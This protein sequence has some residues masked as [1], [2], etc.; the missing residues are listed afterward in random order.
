[1]IQAT[2]LHGQQLSI[3]IEGESL[4]L[5]PVACRDLR[6]PF[7]G[8]S[9][10]VTP[11]GCLILRIAAPRLSPDPALLTEIPPCMTIN[12]GTINETWE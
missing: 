2:N 8:G 10:P 11:P 9:A 1:M 12:A 5:A 7:Y 6:Y 3:W 4:P